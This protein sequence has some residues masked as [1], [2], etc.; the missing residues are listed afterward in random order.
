M[1]AAHL[2]GAQAAAM[3]NAASNEGSGAAMAFMGMNM[4]GNAGG[5]NAQNLFA[6]GQQPQQSQQ[7]QQPQQPQ[8]SQQIQQYT[9]PQ[10]SSAPDTTIE[11]WTCVCGFTGNTGKFCTECAKPKPQDDSWVCSCGTV[12]K[13]KFCMECGK[14][15]PIDEKLS[16]CEKCGWIPPDPTKPSKFCPMCGNQIN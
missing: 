4:A 7:I 3:Q 11:S 16:K 12:N 8:Q 15:K 13:G 14:P 2:V 6:M 1:A 10:P 9:P 5:M